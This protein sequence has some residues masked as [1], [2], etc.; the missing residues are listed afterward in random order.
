M[1]NVTTEYATFTVTDYKNENVLS[2]YSLGITP[3]TFTPSIPDALVNT[4]CTWYFGDGSSS[5]QL[6]ASHAYTY[7]GVYNVQL[8]VYDCE[9]RAKL[10]SYSANITIHDFL[11]NTFNISSTQL[12]A[13]SAGQI[14]TPLIV[15]NTSP[16]YQEMQNVILSVTGSSVPNYFNLTTNKYN[17]LKR[18]NTFYEKNY[19][20]SINDY[21]YVEIDK[22]TFSPTAVYVYLSGTTLITSSS[23]SPNSVYAGTSASKTIYYK[24]DGVSNLVLLSF[25]KDNSTILSKQIN[26]TGPVSFIN[27]LKTV[28]SASIKNNYN[29]NNLSITLNGLD[30]ENFTV[31]SFNIQGTKFFG[32]PIPFVIKIK[33]NID[34]SIKN[35]TGFENTVSI[36]VLSGVNIIPPSYYSVTF[37]SN[38]YLSSIAS[39]NTSYCSGYITLSNYNNILSSVYLQA[40]SYFVKNSTAYSLTG[41]TS[42]FQVVPDGFYEIYKQNED[43]DFEQTIKD[44]RFQEIL[45]DK[46][47]LFTDFIGSIFGGISSSYDLLGKK[48]FERIS[49]FVDNTSNIDKAEINSV[50]DILSLVN[51]QNVR[52]DTAVVRYPNLLKRALSLISINK[53]RLFGYRNQFKENFNQKGITT[54]EVYGKNLGDL[55]DTYTYTVTAG[56]DIVAFEKFSGTFNLLNTFQPVCAVSTTQYKLSEYNDNWGWPLVLPSPYTLADINT[57]Y[58][59]YTVVSSIDGT[60]LNGVINFDNPQTSITFDLPLS[61]YIGVDG[62]AETIIANTLYDSLSLFAI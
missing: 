21:E 9:N 52:F 19:L 27:T 61:S 41:L 15:T 11:T 47:V 23:P 59:F 45:L 57:F 56:T 46:D 17:H 28:L 2:S 51:D 12:L 26:T 16:A 55:I 53:N 60:V 50:V 42:A 62:V 18:Y 1:S 25:K 37:T 38:T 10:A 22:I 29:Y 8:I 44:L 14:S 6:T 4:K 24:D 43:F 54:K 36:K 30:G 3:L 5:T 20:P 32:T 48:I 34:C 31:N 33:D 35:L 7:P 49:N 40:S 13:L 39:D 58:S